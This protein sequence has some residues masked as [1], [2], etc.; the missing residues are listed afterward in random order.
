MGKPH[1]AENRQSRGN[2]MRKLLLS[3]FFTI[4]FSSAAQAGIYIDVGLGWIEE[5]EVTTS[6]HTHIIKTSLPVRDAYIV[7]RGGYRWKN[8][9]NELETIGNEERTFSTFKTYY[10]MEWK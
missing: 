5:V 9:H 1:L 6:H 10:R 4:I 2:I 3:T 8:W 7:L